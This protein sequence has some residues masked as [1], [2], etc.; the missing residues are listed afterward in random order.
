MGKD[1][2]QLLRLETEETV[3]EWY[4][5]TWSSRRSRLGGEVWQEQAQLGRVSGRDLIFKRERVLHGWRARREK[6]RC[7]RA[8]AVVI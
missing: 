8:R 4:G 1:W 7:R 5:W 3:Y 2:R 6:A